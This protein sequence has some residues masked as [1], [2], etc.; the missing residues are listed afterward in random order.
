MDEIIKRAIEYLDNIFSGNSDGHGA[1]H[2]LRVYRNAS[3]IRAAYKC[4]ELYVD[5]GALLHDVD[6]HKL[7]NNKHNENARKFLSDN[8]F[9]VEAIED[10]VEIINSVSFTKNK[11]AK[12]KTLEACIVQDADRLD[13][14]GAVGIAR[15]FMYS[16]RHK[17]G[18]EDSLKHFDEKLLLLKDMM[19][20]DQAKRL[21][22]Q[23]DKFMKEFLSEINDELNN[24]Q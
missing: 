23:R 9:D 10:I 5:L 8:N 22:D 21:A 7:F 18:I 16:G 19:N 17:R 24:K 15:T 14:I 6:D 11:G 1:D 13:A 20:T 12:P 4:N 2:S 3:M